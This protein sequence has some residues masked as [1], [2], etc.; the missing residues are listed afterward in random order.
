M[1]LALASIVLAAPCGFVTEDQIPAVIAA[2]RLCLLLVR[3]GAKRFIAPAQDVAAMI[4]AVERDGDYVRDVSFPPAVIGEACAFLG[5]DHPF[6]E[7]ARP[8]LQAAVA[9]LKTSAVLRAQDF[10]EADC[11]GVF[12]GFGVISDADPGL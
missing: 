2:D 8:R 4:Q 5:A 7:R 12:D 11:G 10:N 3:C 9:K 6:P 1:N